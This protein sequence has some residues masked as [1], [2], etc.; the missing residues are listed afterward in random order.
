MA[1]SPGWDAIDDALRP[2]YGDTEPHHLAT[3]LKWA[4]GGPDPLDGISVYARTEP[5]PHWHYISYGMTELYEKGEESDPAESGWGFEF[6]FRLVRDE[7]DAEPPV[8]AANLLQNLAR[9]VFTSGN[10]FEPGHHMNVNGPIEAEREDSDVRALAFVEDPELGTIATPHGRVQF[11]QVVGL[12]TDEYAAGGRWSTTALLDTLAPHL[13]LFVTDPGRRSLL[14]D[15]EIARTVREGT[16][17]DGSSSGALYVSTVGWDR[18]GDATTLRLGALQATALAEAL[19]G[20]LPHGRPLMLQAEDAMLVFAPG[21]AYAVEEPD[22]GQLVV[23]VP[24]SAVG[25]LTAAIR[26]TA[27]STPVASLPGLTIEIV[28]T[29]MRDQYGEK[30]GE[31]VG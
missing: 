18:S 14:D 2:L 15:P 29:E 3:L 8:W 24:E 16:E 19:G 22:E 11:L 20:R 30:T 10:W 9:Y 13:P 17:R 6:T 21:D 27:G 23:H 12:T 28:P 4:L 1:D 25:D 26:P 5:V 7:A 31:V